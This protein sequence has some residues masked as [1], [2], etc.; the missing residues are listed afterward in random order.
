MQKTIHALFAEGVVQRP[1]ASWLVPLL[2]LQKYTFENKNVRKSTVT[3]E[4][5]SISEND[6]TSPEN[7]PAS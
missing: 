4:N 7:V 6:I 3:Q 5:Q 1:E 2:F